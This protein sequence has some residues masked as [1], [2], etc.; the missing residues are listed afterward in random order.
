M[1]DEP[2]LTRPRL[3]GV[4]LIPYRAADQWGIMQNIFRMWRD[5]PDLRFDVIAL[6]PR[7]LPRH[8]VDA[9]QEGS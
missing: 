6:A 8:I 5:F 7:R 1:P 9:W 4:D 2:R 3:C